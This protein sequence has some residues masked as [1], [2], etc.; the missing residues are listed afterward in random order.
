MKLRNTAFTLGIS[1]ATATGLPLLKVNKNHIVGSTAV[2]VGAGLIISLKDK[3]DKN[4]RTRNY[5]YFLI[6]HKTN[7]NL[8]TMN[9]NK[10]R[11]VFTEAY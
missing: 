5:E 7:S 1:A 2:V 8:Q 9:G 6:E 3:N 11:F 10:S 4:L